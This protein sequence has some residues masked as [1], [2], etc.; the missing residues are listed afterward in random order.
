MCRCLFN[1]KYFAFLLYFFRLILQR[2]IKT[3]S[4]VMQLAYPCVSFHISEEPP[5][6][7]RHVDLFSCL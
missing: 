2:D 1:I 5:S 4:V 7:A 6:F 3:A